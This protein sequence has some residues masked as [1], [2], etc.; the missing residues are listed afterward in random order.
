[1]RII[2]HR[3]APS[4]APENSI[5]SIKAAIDAGVDGIEFDVRLSKDGKLFLCHD[6]TL[7]RT[8]DVDERISSLTAT[9]LMKIKGPDGDH[10]PTLEEALKVAGKT[11]LYIEAKARNWAKPLVRALAKH[12]NKKHYTVIAFNHQELFKFSQYCPDIAVYVLEHRN[13]FDAINAARVYGF[14]GIDVN[15]WTMNPLA[16]Y[17]CKRHNLGIIVFTANTPWIAKIFQKLYPKISITTNVP[18]KMIVK[19]SIR[20]KAV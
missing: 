11:P 6:P 2:G 17:L 13:P 8:H 20:R 5:R 18:Q 4:L 15:Y 14:D 9:A 19:K 3:G 12:P 1:M 10:I 7:E 16:Y